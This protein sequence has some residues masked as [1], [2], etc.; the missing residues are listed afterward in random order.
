MTTSPTAA[1]SLIL[2][3][4]NAHKAAEILGI[5][6]GPA[7]VE[8]LTADDA[9]L[10]ADPEED[11]VER[12]DTFRENAIAKARHFAARADSPALADDSGLVVDALDGAPGVRTKRFAEDAG[13]LEP[14]A[15]V[16]AA[17]NAL[18]LERLRGVEGDER[19]ARF[20]C[21]AALVAPSGAAW[22]FV[23][24][25]PGLIAEEPRGGG[26]FGYDPVFHVPALG[27]TTAELSREEKNRYSH[28]G[29][30]FRAVAARLGAALGTMAGDRGD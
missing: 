16:D 2:G 28:R 20:V 21:V 26:G 15:D 29:R 24:T 10:E 19:S 22:T 13:A 6:G 23:G 17:N 30:A 25:C 4:R 12:F 14:G 9:G 1:T 7:P 11:A 18:L 27:R 8:I 5:L 3:T